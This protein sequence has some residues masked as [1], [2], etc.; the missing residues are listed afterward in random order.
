VSSPKEP[1]RTNLTDAQKAET[2]KTTGKDADVELS[3]EALEDRIAP[4][5]TV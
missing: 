1:V 2:S 5:K 3:V 4:M